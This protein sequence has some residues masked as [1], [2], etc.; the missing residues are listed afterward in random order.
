MHSAA[1]SG[2]WPHSHSVLPDDMWTFQ[3]F[4]LVLEVKYCAWE[5]LGAMGVKS[6]PGIVGILL[7]ILKQQSN[8][9][10]NER[11]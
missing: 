1:L 8:D 10:D 11:S 7:L 4:A 5:L 6:V 9:G 3:G 2:T